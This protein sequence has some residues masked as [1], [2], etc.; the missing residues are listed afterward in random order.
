MNRDSNE[1]RNRIADM[2]PLSP[3]QRG[4]LF[5][6]LLEPDSGLYMP[7]VV[8]RLR[9]NLDVAAL[10]AAFEDAV[11]EHPVLRTGVFWEERDEPFQIVFQDTILLFTELDWRE[12][13]E[14][15]TDGRLE[16]F[17]AVSHAT[18]FE[19][20]RAPLH[21]A[22]LI[23][24]R[25]D[26]WTLVWAYHHIILDG[27]SAARVLE[28]VFAKA[29]L[30]AEA[31]RTLPPSGRFGDYVAWIEKRPVADSEPFW[32]DY[33]GPEDAV[34]TL[35]FSA[36]ALAPTDSDGS[37]RPRQTEVALDELST[38]RLRAFAESVGVTV[39][40]LVM[41]TFA[42]LMGRY[43]HTRD[44]RFGK[45]VTGRPPELAGASSMV[46]LF[47]NTVPVA[48]H[49]MPERPVGEFL[50]AVQ[51]REAASLAHEHVPLR[52]IQAWTN[53]GRSLFECLFV[54]ESY[55]A[56][57]ALDGADAA[58]CLEG[59]EFDER[60]HFPL[61][62]QV[63]EGN[64]LR[65]SARYDGRRFETADLERMLGDFQRLLLSVIQSPNTA[66]GALTPAGGLEMNPALIGRN[67]S[68]PRS[69]APSLLEA[70]ESAG[71]RWRDRPAVWTEAGVLTYA[72]LH[73]RANGL[74][75]TLAEAG[76]GCEDRVAVH[77]ERSAEL[78]VGVLG[79]LK[80]GAVY[81]P[82]DPAQPTSRLERIF[83]NATPRVLLHDAEAETPLPL[84]AFPG[85]VVDL[86]RFD[87]HA[88]SPP[89]EAPMFDASNA[90]YAIYTSGSTGQPKGV[91]NTE[92]ALRNR[93]AWMQDR[94]ALTEE[95]V[96]LHK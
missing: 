92:G 74:A 84:D 66:V 72:E 85:L 21:R 33:L 95:D 79:I 40:T 69:E 2:Y 70:F 73:A 11:A 19:L 43:G 76:I 41:S 42:L 89:K 57:R 45:T 4:L 77:L 64:E 94:F 78:L 83:T 31:L 58:L 63:A 18:P 39:N 14:T 1:R 8:L 28:Q 91:V 49:L 81:L 20:K 9:G 7:H 12:E 30:G 93:L 87:L 59:V 32:R 82:L 65:L 48:L 27:W 53:H 61:L 60:T 51:R 5:H 24:E 90:A 88:A 44:V 37:S 86:P 6:S 16:A 23:R 54:F 50:A 22:T 71:E 3:M 10:R 26:R 56:P 47:I 36:P 34:S 17:L 46:G 67:A 25:G 55:P 38:R 68:T 62:L 35:P 75:A 13:R 15:E 96:V 52:Q 80:A 29:L